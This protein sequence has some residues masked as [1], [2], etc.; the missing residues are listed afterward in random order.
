MLDNVC[1]FNSFY[2]LIEHSRNQNK[3]KIYINPVESDMAAVTFNGLIEFIKKFNTFLS[4][5]NIGYQDKI[6]VA[7]PNTTLHA[8][9]LLSVIAT[10]RIFVPINP[11]MG[12]SEINYII[13]EVKPSLIIHS[14]G[15]KEF[16]ADVQMA[17]CNIINE[18][19]FFEQILK[20][21]ES[22]IIIK[23][24]DHLIAEVVYTSGSTG[25]PKGVVISQKNLISNTIGIFDR[26]KP[27]NHHNFLTITPL[28]H[29]SGQFFSTFVPLLAGA[30]C[31]VIRP[32]LALSNFWTFIKKFDIHWTLGMPTHINFLL[33]Q[34]V[35]NISTNLKAIVIGGARLEDT[36]HRKFQEK[37][38]IPILKT[39]GLTE[40]CSFATC[41]YFNKNLRKIGSS[42]KPLKTNEI[43][44]FKNDKFCEK[45]HELGE[46]RIRGGNIFSS[47]LNQEALTASKFDGN[48]FRTGD[49]GF[50]DDEENLYVY[51]RIDNMIIVNGENVYPAEVE[52]LVP[53]LDGVHLAILSSLPHPISGQ[54][55][56]LIYEGIKANADI[57]RQ[58]CRILEKHIA[59]YKIPK[60][61]IHI[62][63]LKL[64]KIPTANN[65]KILRKQLN[66]KLHE[67]YES[68][69]SQYVE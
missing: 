45:T 27:E 16:L 53:L 36:N 26:I 39:Y 63:A 55:L 61:F 34:N 62:S 5:Q 42:G 6:I 66:N 68:L 29:N 59:S 50:M 51:D 25:T 38:G 37:F 54:E 22:D 7:L 48:W 8:L 31:T 32:E 47:Y 15:E 19:D 67:L 20:L 52:N 44:I 24:S 28:F 41:D 17:Q 60:K 43:K 10:A 11:K 64:E 58:W 18:I 13:R 57:Q 9:I 69:H 21:S 56:V 12:Y 23:E 33:Q 40:T 46:I 65:G 49:L 30:T 2:Q 14:Q 4:I 35:E 3:D 1:I